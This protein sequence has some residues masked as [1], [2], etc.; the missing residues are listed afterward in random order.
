LK[1]E[2]NGDSQFDVL[3]SA[4][5]SA[6]SLANIIIEGIPTKYLIDELARRAVA[7]G[8]KNMTDSQRDLK[9]SFYLFIIS[10]VCSSLYH[11]CV[12]ILSIKNKGLIMKM[13]NMQELA[14]LIL[15]QA[16]QA[17]TYEEA[18]DGDNQLD[19]LKSAVSSAITLSNLVLEELTTELLIEELARRAVD[20]GAVD[21]TSQFALLALKSM[22]CRQRDSIG[23]KIEG[24]PGEIF[25][26]LE[27]YAE[28]DDVT[29]DTEIDEQF[30]KAYDFGISYLNGY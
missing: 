16:F 12:I 17:D 28:D 29:G 22:D 26:N 15:A 19:T 21:S 25:L 13:N 23:N 18:D 4:I 3:K 10:S 27:D 6:E 24:D 2:D 7:V 20:A 30:K 14:K 5:S 8:A 11:T 1:N 9:L